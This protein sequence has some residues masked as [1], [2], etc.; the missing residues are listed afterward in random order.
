MLPTHEIDHIC[1]GYQ[2]KFQRK[3]VND[4]GK[5]S[6]DEF[7]DIDDEEL[8]LLTTH[9]ENAST[10]GGVSSS[11]AHGDLKRK[12]HYTADETSL[13]K[14]MKVE[15]DDPVVILARSIL[16]KTWGFQGFRLKQEVAIAR[17]ITGGNAAVVFPTGG[18]K[19]GLS[20]SGACV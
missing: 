13:E 18:G 10:A 17:L 19:S 12:N 15:D 1:I 7:G 11:F 20:S 8:V 14:R 16:K 3:S 4:D 6:E 9:V 5:R 2:Q